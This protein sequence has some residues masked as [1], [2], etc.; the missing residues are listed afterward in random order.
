MVFLKSQPN[1]ELLSNWQVFLNLLLNKELPQLQNQ[2]SDTIV[3][4]H[5]NYRRATKDLHPFSTQPMLV[6]YGL[7]KT[8]YLGEGGKDF[9]VLL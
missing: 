8:H 5:M 1:I 9:S 7:W 4:Y 3:Y 2:L 6:L